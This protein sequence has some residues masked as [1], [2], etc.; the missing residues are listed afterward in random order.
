MTAYQSKEFGV[1]LTD[2]A[3]HGVITPPDLPLEKKTFSQ[4]FSVSLNPTKPTFVSLRDR[5]WDRT[6]IQI[7]SEQSGV[8]VKV[9]REI[10]LFGDFEDQDADNSKSSRTWRYPGKYGKLTNSDVHSGRRALSIQHTAAGS[11]AEIRFDHKVKH[12]S[13]RLLTLAGY[14][15][16]KN[17]GRIRGELRFWKTNRKEAPDRLSFEIDEGTH[18]WKLF[19]M[20]FK[21]PKGYHHF[22]PYFYVDPP[23]EGKG[24]VIFDD[25]AVVCWEPR[26]GNLKDGVTLKW[27]NRNDYLRLESNNAQ[28]VDLVVVNSSY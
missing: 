17:A 14:V 16:T 22:V 27:G 4:K 15:K 10:L 13:R 9:G 19:H 20:D 18:D 3:G 12:R 6:P 5:S 2:N 7:K 24:E 23:T 26:A 28:V 11:T 25:V 1:T 21:L 8:N